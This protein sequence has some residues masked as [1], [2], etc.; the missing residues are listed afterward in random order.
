[1]GC[2]MRTC[3][4]LFVLFCSGS[5]F[6]QIQ[7]GSFESNGDPSLLGWIDQCGHGNSYMD[8]SDQGGEWCLELIFGNTQGCF[9]AYFYQL[10][11]DV[12]TGTYL[13]VSADVRTIISG[14]PAR[15]ILGKIDAEGQVVALY[16]DT[17]SAEIWTTIEV[18][19]IIDLEQNESA[20]IILQAGLTGGP[21]GLDHLAYFDQVQ[22]VEQTT[23][24]IDVPE[25]P[26]I[27]FPNPVS[28]HLPIWTADQSDAITGLILFSPSGQELLRMKYQYPQSRIE[29]YLGSLP[30]GPYFL[31]L[32]Q[33]DRYKGYWVFKT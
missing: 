29:L 26:A 30:I 4:F 25:F 23:A 28:D 14:V 11:P 6:A 3:T 2:L 16:S 7:N 27:R 1:M 20:A 8:A 13:K 17:S 9:P 32:Y 33:E 19:G 15:L 18:S 22:L 21:A 5:L 31:L 12:T 10:L 24:T